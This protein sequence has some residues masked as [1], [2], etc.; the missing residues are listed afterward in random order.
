MTAE[1]NRIIVSSAAICGISVSNFSYPTHFAST[2]SYFVSSSGLNHRAISRRR[3]RGCRCRGR[4]CS[5]RSGRSRRGSC[6]VA[7]WCRRSRPSGCG[8]PRPLRGLPSTIATVGPLV[9]NVQQ[10]FVERLALVDRV[11]LL[12]QVAARRAPV[13]GR[14]GAGPCAR[15]GPV[16]S[17]TSRRCTAS[18]FRRISVC[19]MGVTPCWFCQSA[20][21]RRI[22]QR[23]LLPL[24]LREGRGVGSTLRRPLP[25]RER[26]PTVSTMPFPTKTRFPCRSPLIRTPPRNASCGSS[27]SP[28]SPA[29][30]RPSPRK[31]RAALKEVGVPAEAIRF[32]D[33]NTPHPRADADRQPH[34]RRCPARRD[35]A[36]AAVHD[37][38][39]HR[40][41]LCRGQAQCARRERDRAT[42]RKTAPRRRQPHR[43]RRA[44]HAGRGTH[45][46]EAAAPAADAALHRPR[47]ERPLRR[48]A[49]EPRRPRRRRRWASTSMAAA[50]PT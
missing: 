22:R 35:A 25:K 28:A 39:G 23:R 3:S 9:R 37:A 42:R 16:I 17:P 8:R 29:R 49:P 14:R 5:A 38:H 45:R 4:G 47:G 11:V 20:Q 2:I 12:G 34:R 24:L 40:A 26:K 32:D 43:L 36:A 27:P 18:G 44:R 10:R 13:S 48:Q 21:R 31:S 50:P 7:P 41:A 33:A 19:C 15:S 46:A 6:R 1:K 30:K